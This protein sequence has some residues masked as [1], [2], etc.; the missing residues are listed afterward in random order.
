MILKVDPSQM[1]CRENTVK[2]NA[3]VECLGRFFWGEKDTP[4]K[5]DRTDTDRKNIFMQ[6]ITGYVLPNVVID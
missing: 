4:D 5:Q 3:E 6:R 1:M 2:E